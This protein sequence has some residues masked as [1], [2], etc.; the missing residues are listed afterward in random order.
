M[1]LNNIAS[2]QKQ[3]EQQEQEEY[4]DEEY[5]EEESSPKKSFREPQ[6]KDAFKSI[7]QNSQRSYRIVQKDSYRSASKQDSIIQKSTIPKQSQRSAIPKQTLE[8]N[9]SVIKLESPQ[10]ESHRSVIKLESSRSVIKI[11]S[12]PRNPFEAPEEENS[13]PPSN[14]S[15]I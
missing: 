8:S 5:D 4:Y 12:P 15:V 11:D 13:P 14:R 10:M 1:N 7:A 2:L 6:K 9:R 3:K